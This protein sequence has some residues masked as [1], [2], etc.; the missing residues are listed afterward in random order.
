[1]SN[2]RLPI[3]ELLLASFFWGWGFIATKWLL[4]IWSFAEITFIRFLLPFVICIPFVLRHKPWSYFKASFF[5]GFFLGLTILTQTAGLMFTTATKS[6]FLTTLYVVL[7]PVINWF[8]FSIKPTKSL[9][10]SLVLAFL[11]SILLTQN[12][13][14]PFMDVLSGYGFGELLTLGCAVFASLQI[15]S[16]SLL[17]K[18]IENSF[19]FNIWSSLWTSLSSVP[20]LFIF[21]TSD[22]MQVFYQPKAL[23]AIASLTLLSTLLGFTLQVRNQKKLSSNLASLIFLMESPFAFILAFFLLGETVTLAQSIGMILIMS[24]VI[25]SSLKHY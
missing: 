15:I 11:G 8:F 2:S 19:V 9:L 24:G 4:P 25:I 3:F 12:E 23:I 7:V 21:P 5:P 16:I 20:L 14:Q 17:A 13:S 6:A 1:V 10:Y 22:L 18:N